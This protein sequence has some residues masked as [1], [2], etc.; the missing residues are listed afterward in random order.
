MPVGAQDVVV[1]HCIIHQEN[2]CTK[3]LAFAEG[4]KNVVL[5]VDY[6]RARKL[7]HWKFKAFQEY[8]DC[9]HPDVVYFSTVRWLSRAATLMRFWN[10]RQELKLFM[11]SKH[12]N[13]TFLGDEN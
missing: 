2:L 13:V 5:C 9:D 10:L 11:E 12:Q 7:N 1:S 4:M 6:I 8:Q 3:V